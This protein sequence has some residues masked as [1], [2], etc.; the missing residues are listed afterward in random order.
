MTKEE[1]WARQLIRAEE[2]ARAIDRL[3]QEAIKEACFMTFQQTINP[4]KPFEF[5]DYPGLAD[6][7][8]RF[9]RKF[10]KDMNLILVGGVQREWENANSFNDALVDQVLQHLNLP[11]AIVSKYKNRNL[12]A[13]ATFQKRKTLGME[14]SGRVWNL[15]EQFKQELELALDV[16]LGEAKNFGELARDVKQYLNE[17]NKLFRRVRD[18]RGILQ[19]SKK[20]KAYRPGTGVYRSSVK[21]AQRLTRTEVNMAYRRADYE[22]IQQLDFVVGYEVRRSNNKMECGVCDAFVG[23]YPKS[24]IFIGQHPHCRCLLLTILATRAEIDAHFEKMLAGE[25][26]VFKS[27]REVTKMP[28]G[29]TTWI[30]DN[31]KRLEKASTQPYFIKDNF[32]GGRITGGLRL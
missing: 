21:N 30:R 22:R 19:L 2:Y 26:P 13:L 28:E 31:T 17:P 23:V 9:F 10:V 5:K 11:K 20:A 29:W 15:T 32:K 18:K 27:K 6:R 4:D 25:D 8:N 16:G 3:F 1:A 12:E 24:Y 7:V 14:L